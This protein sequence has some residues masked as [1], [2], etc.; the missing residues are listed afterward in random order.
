MSE[1]KINPLLEAMSEI[2]DNNIVINTA[3]AKKSKKRAIII[4]AAAAA[5]MAVGSITAGA[6]MNAPIKT[7][8]NNEPY[9]PTYDVYTDEYGH[10]IETFVYDIPEYAL[11]EEREGQTAVGRVRA[12]YDP[13]LKQVNVI[14]YKLVD[15]EGNEF[16]FGINNKYVDL[17]VDGEFTSRAFGARNMA[18][19]DYMIVRFMSEH[20]HN[21][22]NLD[23]CFHVAKRDEVDD[24]F[25]AHGIDPEEVEKNKITLSPLP[26]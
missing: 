17:R 4:A 12:V 10:T 21:D 8:L 6:I 20:S 5:V 26:F 14:G 2:D 13:E 23:Q 22:Y 24:L 16:L 11:V 7:M 1:N 18:N 3:T 25:R 15:E 9:E 19:G